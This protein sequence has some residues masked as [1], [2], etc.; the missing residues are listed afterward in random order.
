MARK[1]C[2]SGI[3]VE[4]HD[5][6]GVAACILIGAADGGVATAT[7]QEAVPPPAASPRSR[8]GLT[9]IA[10][11]RDRPEPSASSSS[12]N[13]SSS[14]VSNR[15]LRLHLGEVR[16]QRS[17]DLVFEVKK[18]VLARIPCGLLRGNPTCCE[19]RRAV[20]LNRPLSGVR[21]ADG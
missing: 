8:Y 2:A 14:W 19:G 13:S 1:A 3:A 18:C 7:R 15:F 12:H 20:L 11:A 21:P 17:A 10:A 6:I 5:R 4:C 9:V 16:T